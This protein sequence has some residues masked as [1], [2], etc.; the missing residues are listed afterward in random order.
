MAAH[1]K[2]IMPQYSGDRLSSELHPVLERIY[3]N[4]GITSERQLQLGLQNLQSYD[5]LRGIQD[6]VRLLAQAV[7]NQ[8][9][10]LIVGDFDADGATSTALALRALTK[11]GAQN[12]N[13]LVPNRFE[14][15]YGL[16]PEIV[17]LAIGY[18]PDLIVTVDNGISSIQGVEAAKAAGVDQV[19]PAGA[20]V[21]GRD[22]DQPAGK[23]CGY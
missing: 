8:Q 20:V 23:G 21:V 10:I 9:S 7:R 12:V 13:Y 2:K 1:I 3:R 18:S 17:Q 11:M 14:F 22:D 5:Q 16:T 4:R 6:A 19:E 15:G